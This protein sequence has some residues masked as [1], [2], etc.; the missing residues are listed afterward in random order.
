[1]KTIYRIFFIVFLPLF[2][3]SCGNGEGRGP[4]S[5]NPSSQPNVGIK[6][7]PTEPVKSEPSNASA[8]ESEAFN[9]VNEYRISKGKTP[10]IWDNTI[11]NVS[12]GHSEDMANKVVPIGHDGFNQRASTLQA[13]LKA[14]LIGENVAVNKGHSDPVETAVNGWIKSPG[15]EANMVGDFTKTGM[16]VAV[17]SS[18]EYY[19]T[20]MFVR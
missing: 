10:L 4:T 1:M 16:G 19:F 6:N 3:I 8:L 2:L 18:G 12:R 14:T 20:Q 13:A 7:N 5:R 15:H 11:A 17:N 9:L